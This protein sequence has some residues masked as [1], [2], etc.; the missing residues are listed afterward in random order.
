MDAT[1]ISE[2]QSGEILRNKMITTEMLSMI[3]ISEQMLKIRMK[4]CSPVCYD[5]FTILW[6]YRVIKTTIFNKTVRQISDFYK[7]IYIIENLKRKQRIE[8]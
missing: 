6:G 3:F 1:G 2:G 7:R 4:S 5:S 8:E